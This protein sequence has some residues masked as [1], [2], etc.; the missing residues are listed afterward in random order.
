MARFPL[1]IEGPAFLVFSKTADG[2]K[3]KKDKVQ[4][5]MM[6]SFRLSKAYAL[7]CLSAANSSCG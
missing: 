7:L 5:L 3:K 2:A 6:T 1:F 4:E